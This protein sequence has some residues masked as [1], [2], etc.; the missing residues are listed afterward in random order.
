MSLKSILKP[1]IPDKLLKFKWRLYHK[2]EPQILH[3]QSG[4][5]SHYFIMKNN[6]AVFTPNSGNFSRYSD[7]T[8]R[9]A[10]LFPNRLD[11]L[12]STLGIGDSGFKMQS[13]DNFNSNRNFAEELG[14][15]FNNYGSDKNNHG[16]EYV[17]GE[18]VSQFSKD[19]K[20]NVLEIGLGTNNPNLISTMGTS[21]RP[22]ASIRAF[23][24]FLPNSNIY[25]ADIDED[26]L[27]RESR[28]ATAKVDQTDLDS[29]EKM[30]R[31]LNCYEF[32]I[33]ID[34]GLHAVEANINT[35]IFGLKSIR[36]NGWIII[37]DIPERTI[38]VWKL[39]GRLIPSENF[40]SYLLNCKKDYVFAV[41]KIR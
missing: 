9:S 21:G 15:L 25:G 39:I 26:I 13:A 30:T 11:V 7:L 41:Q 3:I 37:E 38:G 8:Y 34:D 23:R 27:F 20:L 6:L 12:I 40:N 33:V 35:L 16:Y 10:N 28:I 18:V 5:T 17:Y 14:L 19:A 36:K 22:G 2:F 4:I 24:D 31:E 32:D 1:F 29:F